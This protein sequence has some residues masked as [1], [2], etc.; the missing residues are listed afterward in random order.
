MHTHHPLAMRFSGAGL[1]GAAAFGRLFPNLP[2]LEFD[3]AAA[4]AYARSLQSAE[5]DDNPDLPAAYTYF[6]Q[7]VDHDLTFDPVPDIRDRRAGRA[8]VNAR[9]PRFDLD[10]V[11]GS[12]FVADPHLYDRYTPGL[13]LLGKG[14]DHRRSPSPDTSEDDLPRNDQNVMVSQIQ[15]AFLRLHNRVYRERISAGEEAA[16]AFESARRTVRWHYQWVVLHDFLPRLAG[17]WAVSAVLENGESPARER[18]RGKWFNLESPRIPLEFS[19]AVYRFGHSM[20][21]DSY[22]LSDDFES[23][24]GPRKIFSADGEGGIAPDLRAGRF[25]PRAWS[26]Q[27]DRFLLF[28]G[29][30]TPQASQRID[31]KMANA[32]RHVPGFDPS[33]LAL[34]NLVRGRSLGLPSGQD[35]AHAMGLT[36]LPASRPEPLWL[37]VLREAEENCE[38]LRLGPVAARIVAEVMLGVLAA[39][40]DSFVNAAPGWQPSPSMLAPGSSAFELKDLIHAAGLPC[41]RSAWLR[42]VGGDF[43]KRPNELGPLP[44]EILPGRGTRF[45]GQSISLHRGRVAEVQM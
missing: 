19:G 29:G 28:P 1:Y 6:G 40:P 10:S 14:R 2:A 38:G 9:T 43:V 39:D 16:T 7:F 23:R 8:V 37:Y 13:M 27:W 11:Y 17:Q 35:V 3:D 26:L 22:V 45:S 18:Y 41:D 32:L 15:L 31:R 24:L 4:A 34:R 30:R 44:D 5:V 25:L 42:W 12:G 33:D 20:V 36:P 21:R